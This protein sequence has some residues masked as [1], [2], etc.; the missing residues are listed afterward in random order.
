M[1]V[2]CLVP[3]ARVTEPSADW[4]VPAAAFT[5]SAGTAGQAFAQSPSQLDLG[6]LAVSLSKR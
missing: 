4:S 5:P 3:S 2:S 6:G 1:M